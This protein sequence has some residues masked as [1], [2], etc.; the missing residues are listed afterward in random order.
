MSEQQP[1]ETYYSELART[2]R[3]HVKSLSEHTPPTGHEHTA[4]TAIEHYRQL[5]E[6]YEALDQLVK[7]IM[8][9]DHQEIDRLIREHDIARH[10]VDEAERLAQRGGQL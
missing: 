3:E 7:A 2:Y 4:Q 10:E 5:A 6:Q 1:Q 9:E 8:R